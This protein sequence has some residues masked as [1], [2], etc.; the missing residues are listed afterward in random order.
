MRKI[1]FKPKRGEVD[2]T[3]IRWA[4]I[5]NCVV[6]YKDKILVVKRSKEVGFYPGYWN[7]VSGFL[8]DKKSIKQKVEEELN[9]ELGI[10]KN[11]IRKIKLGKI[12][13]KDAPRYKKTWIVHPVLV[14]V[15]SNKLKLDWEAENYKWVNFNEAKKLKLVPG[16][17]EVLKRL[18]P[19]I[20]K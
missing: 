9:E 12:F 3:N 5:V 17:D 6:K 7:G 2:Y 14:E 18:S 8:N 4:P 1:K 13:E 16:F 11:K 10:L 15:K 19:W 20:R